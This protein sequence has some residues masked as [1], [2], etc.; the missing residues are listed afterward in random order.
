[1]LGAEDFVSC[2]AFKL[3]MIPGNVIGLSY[4]MI[5][6]DTV[7]AVAV[8]FKHKQI[9]TLGAVKRIIIAEWVLAIVPFLP[10]LLFD[11]DGYTDVPEFN[12]CAAE[13]AALVETVLTLMLPGVLT[14]CIA[15]A[16]NVYV[17]IKTYHIYKKDE[18][19]NRLSGS[20]GQTTADKALKQKKI[21]KIKR[22]LKP[23]DHDA[24]DYI[25]R[26]ILQYKPSSTLLFS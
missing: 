10:S 12:F 2:S 6:A 14:S 16:L 11:V 24:G 17:T 22:Q 26:N 4:M 8:P 13:G 23:N 1:M 19:E 9:M 21:K 3:S 18:N 5:S 20:S 25:R 15:F 7:I